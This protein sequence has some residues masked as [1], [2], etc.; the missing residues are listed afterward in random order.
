MLADTDYQLRREAFFLHDLV[1]LG[2]LD[3]AVSLHH[4][5]VFDPCLLMMETGS[6]LVAGVS[7]RAGFL[8]L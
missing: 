3:T 1:G 8:P 5:F 4:G 6:V 2:V 7:G